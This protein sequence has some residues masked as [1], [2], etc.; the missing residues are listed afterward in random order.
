[1]VAAPFA[2]L[3]DVLGFLP[4]PLL[5]GPLSPIV[6]DPFPCVGGLNRTHANERALALGDVPALA[7]I[8]V[9]KDAH[10]AAAGRVNEDFLRAP[11]SWFGLDR[12]A[13][14]RPGLGMAPLRR[15]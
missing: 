12:L 10:P 9:G 2:F 14:A 3:V 13:A 1:M 15:L 6:A 7:G 11:K 5:P 4:P 8:R